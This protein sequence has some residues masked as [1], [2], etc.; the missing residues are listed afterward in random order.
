MRGSVRMVRLISTATASEIR[1]ERMV[2]ATH[3][4]A[5]RGLGGSHFFPARLSPASHPSVTTVCFLLHPGV[6]FRHPSVTMVSFLLHPGV[7][8]REVPIN[9]SRQQLEDFHGPENCWCLCDAWS[10]LW[11]SNSRKASVHIA[12][13][14]KNFELDPQ[15]TE[16]TLK[17]MI[18]LHCRPP[19]GVP[20]AERR[21]SLSQS[22]MP[23]SLKNP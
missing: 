16:V 18:L 12:Y 6:K 21:R 9:V 14:R 7:K 4:G 10:H 8:F 15:G 19:E 23:K 20:L 22:Q 1:E 2:D 5:G 3:R 11:T 13:L 17:G